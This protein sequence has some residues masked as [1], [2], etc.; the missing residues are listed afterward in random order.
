MFS[1]LVLLLVILT[2][3]RT[4]AS[5]IATTCMSE[6]VDYS[7]NLDS[8][9]AFSADQLAL[10]RHL[11][12]SGQGGDGW[13]INPLG[14]SIVFSSARTA[15]VRRFPTASG[16]GPLGEGALR[17]AAGSNF[18]QGSQ[19][20]ASIA[21]NVNAVRFF[22][23]TNGSQ[24]TELPQLDGYCGDNVAIVD[25]FRTGRFYL[26]CANSSHLVD[27][28]LYSYGAFESPLTA[29]WRPRDRATGH[30]V[31]PQLGVGHP[32]DIVLLAG[33]RAAGVTPVDWL[34]VFWFD[35]QFPRALGRQNLTLSTPRYD[36]A[37]ASFRRGARSLEFLVAGG[38][39][40]NGKSAHV[41]HFA[42][43]YN[44]S[45]T[46]FDV[47]NITSLVVPP[48]SQ[49]RGGITAIQF[50]LITVFAGGF[51]A[52]GDTYT[53]IDVY[54]RV[55][56]G[57][58]ARTLP[59]DTPFS[60]EGIAFVGPLHGLNLAVLTPA[61]M[62]V[63]AA[64][65]FQTTRYAA[66][67]L[68][69]TAFVH[70]SSVT[71]INTTAFAYGALVPVRHEPRSV[72][73][74]DGLKIV[75]WSFPA[76]NEG[77]VAVNQTLVSDML[78]IGCL[79]FIETNRGT[80]SMMGWVDSTIRIRWGTLVPAPNSLALVGAAF[81]NS[82]MPDVTTNEHKW[83]DTLKHQVRAWSY[84]FGGAISSV[85]IVPGAA[86]VQREGSPYLY[87][88]GGIDYNGGGNRNA[89][90]LYHEDSL[91]TGIIA[92]RTGTLAHAHVLG[93]AVQTADG[94]LWHAGGFVDLPQYEDMQV[95][96][97]SSV[98]VYRSFLTLQHT[99]DL[100]VARFS[101]AGVAVQY[102]VFFIGGATSFEFRERGY[103]MRDMSRVVDVFT[104]TQTGPPTRHSFELLHTGGLVAASVMYDRFIVI[105]GGGHARPEAVAGSNVIEILDVQTG[106]S[107]LMHGARSQRF[108]G[109]NAVVTPS[110]PVMVVACT[111]ASTL[112]FD[113]PCN[114]RVTS[115]I[116]LS[117][118]NSVDSARFDNLP[119]TYTM[120][121]DAT[122]AEPGNT[123][124]S[125]GYKTYLPYDG[126]IKCLG[127]MAIQ[128]SMRFDIQFALLGTVF[129]PQ[130]LFRAGTV[131]RGRLALDAMADYEELV[132]HAF[133]PSIWLGPGGASLHCNNDS[134]IVPI[135]GWLPSDRNHTI[136]IRIDQNWRRVAFNGELHTCP[137]PNPTA[138]ELRER[139]PPTV[140][141]SFEI[142]GTSYLADRRRHLLVGSESIS[143]LAD[144]NAT[145][146][147][148]HNVDVGDHNN[149]D[150]YNGDNSDDHHR[151]HRNH[152][153]LGNHRFDQH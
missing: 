140:L 56:S 34:D 65:P 47:C 23:T 28:T 32:Y 106:E 33:G 38:L 77:S 105:V 36:V 133:V 57:F 61:G 153:R 103:R 26:F 118:L 80:A 55:D 4:V 63:C 74:A 8:S 71:G 70:A 109:H 117:M 35:R 58:I 110:P 13:L 145:N 62:E 42:C 151:H 15:Q 14:Q 147:A 5:T 43:S 41:D 82:T 113:S 134:T 25:Q 7:T 112:M 122:C 54:E 45:I 66:S 88:L 107:M 81:F 99:L 87:V 83:V 17:A 90:M 69:N 144:A 51:D 31:S 12:T 114:H 97:S 6:Y 98:H 44:S 150:G 92:N 130:L 29:M 64:W 141:N 2:A 137:S 46:R 149:N 9:G 3:A 126:E 86:Y 95:T 132:A 78:T 115:V 11:P 40:A 125:L 27:T 96:I 148:S 79:P 24:V 30:L 124:T 91:S 49:S 100:S 67:D 146:N 93:A 39:T 18:S 102:Q 131:L 111:T 136:S 76:A 128:S 10:R 129:E 48:L 72:W 37:V 142:G 50:G 84:P 68:T 143:R 104:L 85:K 19:I 123:C 22:V 20:L 120:D 152:H 59:W 135:T 89:S 127:C 108:A 94:T 53:E 121:H 21:P 16:L 139:F 101:L 116:D 73:V 75:Q 60:P 119:T 1:A 52:S 138:L